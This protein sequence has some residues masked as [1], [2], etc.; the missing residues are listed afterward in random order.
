MNRVIIELDKDGKFEG[1]ASDTEIELY[2][3]QPTATEPL[4][5]YRAVDVG[6]E[7]V[8]NIIK[9]E[10]VYYGGEDELVDIKPCK[11]TL[12]IIKD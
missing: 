4:Y 1:V 6:V 3:Y 12:Q 10:P 11:P 9:D 8:R 7:M 5:H 2:T